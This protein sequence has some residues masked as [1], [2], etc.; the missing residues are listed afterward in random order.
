MK[1]EQQILVEAIELYK[2][3]HIAVLFSGGYDSMATAHRMKSINTDGLPVSTWAIDTKLSADGW[4]DYVEGVAGELSL[5]DFHIYNNQ[6]GYAEFERWVTEHGCPYS[7]GG[8]NRGYNRLKNR[9]IDAIHMRYKQNRSDTTLF[10]TGVRRSE[11]VARAQWSEYSRKKKSNICYVCPI[12]YWSDERI[13]NYRIQNDLPTNPFYDTVG[14]SGD[15]QCNWGNFCTLKKLQ[16]YSPRLANG[17]V[18]TLD[19]LS[20][21]HHGYGWDENPP[22]D[23]M[24]YQGV[25]FPDELDSLSL[26]SNCSRSID[27][28]RIA[29]AVYLQRHGL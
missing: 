8:H 27:K 4:T 16:Q 22:P 12:V 15:C 21:E 10:V 1:S 7:P 28:H 11:S 3:R 14:G 26:C 5:P 29:E 20:R 23:W 25:L 2:P 17:N 13:A 6:S 24:K 9:A 18:A 19:R